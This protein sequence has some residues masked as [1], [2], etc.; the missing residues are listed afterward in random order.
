[1]ILYELKVA[2]ER[3]TGEDNPAKVKETYIVEGLNCTDVEGRLLEEIKPFIS[4]DCEVTSCKKVQYFDILDNTTGDKW[5]KGKI[6]LITVEEDGKETRKAATLLIQAE[7]L[8]QALKRLKEQ[9]SHL[10]CELVSLLRTPVMD[11]LRAVG[12]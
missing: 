12:E 1:M 7:D 4:G 5:Y 11:V 10:D 8:A 3:Q 6:E 2:Y 9:V